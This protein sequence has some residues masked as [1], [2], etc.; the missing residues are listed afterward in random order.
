[1]LHREV[2]DVDSQRFGFRD[3]TAQSFSELPVGTQ[4][5]NGCGVYGVFAQTRVIHD[6]TPGSFSHGAPVPTNRSTGSL[7]KTSR[8]NWPAF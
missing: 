1:M 4:H 5:W 7:L 3:P 6:N 8:T 2:G